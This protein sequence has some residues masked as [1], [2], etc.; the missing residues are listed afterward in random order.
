VPRQSHQARFAAPLDA[1]VAALLKSLAKR[2]WAEGGIEDPERFVPRVGTRYVNERGSVL[3]RG[4]VLECL[5]PVSVTLYETLFDRPCRVR[6]KLRWR[7]EPGDADSLL[8]LEARYDLNG[9]ATLRHRHWRRQIAAHCER[10]L[11][12]VTREVERGRRQGA[13]ATAGAMGQSQGKSSI[14]VTK[15]TAVSGKPSFR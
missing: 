12:F 3:R 15:T 13:G 7:L 10:M 5:R 11:G 9:A 4:R 8:R 2:R 1:G 6:L 14:V